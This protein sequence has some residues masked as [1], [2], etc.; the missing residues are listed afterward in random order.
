MTRGGAGSMLGVGGTRRKLGREALRGGA[1]GGRV[2]GPD[3]EAQKRELLRRLRE[4]HAER[5]PPVQ[6]GAPPPND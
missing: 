6:E 2:G 5:R 1:R 4:R 3:A